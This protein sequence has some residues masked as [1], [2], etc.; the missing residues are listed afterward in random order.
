MQCECN[1]RQSMSQAPTPE[2]SARG[3]IEDS[4]E[5]VKAPTPESA[6]RGTAKAGEARAPLNPQSAGKG[7][8]RK[9]LLEWDAIRRIAEVGMALDV[10]S[11]GSTSIARIAGRARGLENMFKD[12]VCLRIDVRALT[13]WDVALWVRAR[14]Q[15]GTKTAEQYAKSTLTLAEKVTGEKFYAASELVKAQASPTIGNSANAEPPKPAVPPKW[16]HIVALEEAIRYGKT[17]QQ[18]VMA[19]LF[20]FLVHS[21]HRCSN[22][23]GSRNLSLTADAL[24]GEAMLSRE[25][26]TSS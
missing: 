20:V 26:T 23:Q 8:R 18:R 6:A 1:G 3:K 24:M 9:K 5:E 2:S 11:S 22:G 13:E 17:P 10:Y 16:T 7:I 21:S 12:M 15:C 14:V 19:V 25:P 4:E